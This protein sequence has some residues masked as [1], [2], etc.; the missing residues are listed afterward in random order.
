MRQG[1]RRK[2]GGQRGSPE[3]A[4]VRRGVA[5][6]MFGAVVSVPPPPV[7]RSPAPL[8]SP[9]VLFQP[10]RSLPDPPMLA[11]GNAPSFRVPIATAYAAATTRAVLRRRIYLCPFGAHS[12]PP[13]R[14][15]PPFPPKLSASCAPGPPIALP[16]SPSPPPPHALRHPFTC[17][18][19]P[20]RASSPSPPPN[21]AFP[22]SPSDDTSHK[23]LAFARQRLTN[24]ADE[25][26]YQR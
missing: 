3:R 7:A 12:P 11:A 4:T 18:A 25:G 24:K 21:R 23:F 20:R 5:F 14:H 10:P 2:G 1:S 9:V 6:E 16:T 13:L 26:N 8:P 15:P 19:L 22:T 17:D